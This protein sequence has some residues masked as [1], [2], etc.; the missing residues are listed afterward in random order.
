MFQT[1]LAS[2]CAKN[3]PLKPWYERLRR[4]KSERVALV[5]RSRKLL[6]I[7]YILLK[8]QQLFRGALLK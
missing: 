1:T 6:V 5:A 8:T 3:N 7:T 2:L 4:W